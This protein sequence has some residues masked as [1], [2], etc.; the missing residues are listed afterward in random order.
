MWTSGT[1]LPWSRREPIALD[2]LDPI[3][4]GEAR[5]LA[6]PTLGYDLPGPGYE[7]PDPG[8]YDIQLTGYHSVTYEAEA[9]L[10]TWS[11]G[12]FVIE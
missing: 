6:L 5:E 1:L 3:M 4:P 8:Y 12:L 11:G 2:L 10:G 7:T 9:Y